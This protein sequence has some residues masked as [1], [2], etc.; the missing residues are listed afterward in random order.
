MRNN[1]L[2]NRNHKIFLWSCGWMLTFWS[3]SINMIASYAI[4]FSRISHMTGPAS[5][6][7]RFLFTDVRMALIIILI[8]LSFVFGAYL[9]AVTGGM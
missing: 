7:S 4:L 8:V 9:S 5:D 3:G 1:E 2:G 6:L